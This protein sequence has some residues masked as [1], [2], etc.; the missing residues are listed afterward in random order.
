MDLRVSTVDANQANITYELE[1][2]KQ[3]QLLNNLCISGITHRENQNLHE[4]FSKICSCLEIDCNS[5]KIAGI[6]RTRGK[7]NSSIIVQLKSEHLKRIILAA[8]KSKQ[9]IIVDELEI[10]SLTGRH[11]RNKYQ[12][13]SNTVFFPHPVYCS[14][15]IKARGT[16]GLLV[17]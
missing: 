5:N 4:I 2:L 6:Y 14:A 17:F 15:G 12:L 10:N 11:E 1:L 3:K 8:K 7:F 16:A 13:P 9:S